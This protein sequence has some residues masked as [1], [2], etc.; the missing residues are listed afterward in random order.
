MQA[1]RN[2]NLSTGV[3]V[4]V[5]GDLYGGG[6]SGGGSNTN[7]HNGTAAPSPAS[8]S[9]ATD[10]IKKWVLLFLDQ[11]SFI[12]HIEYSNEKGDIV[13]PPHTLGFGCRNAGA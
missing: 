8:T 4:D 10:N 7:T 13:S 11:N 1:I 2:I 9:G 12:I 5:L 3:L 6:G